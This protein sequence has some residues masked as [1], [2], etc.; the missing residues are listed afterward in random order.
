MSKNEFTGFPIAIMLQPM[1]NEQLTTLDLSHN[2]FHPEN[3][4]IEPLSLPQL[5][6]LS[7]VSTGLSSLD[8]LCT[9]LAAP[10]LT[11]LNISCNRLSGHVPRLREHFPRLSVVLATDGWFDSI[12]TKSV[13]GLTLLDLTN[14]HIEGDID[15]QR[16]DW[17]AVGCNVRL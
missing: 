10:Q 11:E 13:V 4:L 14:N 2:P 9:Y 12:E 16:I 17:N 6:K 1:V 8:A 5:R 3:Y 7:I 15:D